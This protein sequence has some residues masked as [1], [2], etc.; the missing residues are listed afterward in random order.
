MNTTSNSRR[1]L[2]AAALAVLGA[3]IQGPWDFYPTDPPIFNGLTVTGY[4]LAGRPIEHV[5]FERLLPL[6]EENTQAFAFYDSA[7]VIITGN[8]GGTERPMTLTAVADTPNCFK[9]DP[10]ALVERGKNYELAAGIKWDSAGTKVTTVV[11]GTAR[12]PTSFSLHDSASAP[13]IARTGGV[14]E[15]IFDARFLASLPIKVREVMNKEYGDTLGKLQKDTV[16]LRKYLAVHGAAIQKRL[17]GLLADDNTIYHKGDTLFYLNGALNTLSHYYS[18]DRS[19]DVGSVLITQRF[20]P[21]GARPETSFDSPVGLKP[22]SFEYYFPGNH[23][24]LL[25]YPDGRSRKGWNLLDSIGVVNVFFHTLKNTLFF[26]GMEKAYYSYLSTVTQVQGGGGGEADPRVIPK[27]NVT[28]AHGVFVG[29]IP[30]SFDIVIRTDPLT[31]IYPL[32]LVHGMSCNKD[33]WFSGPDCRNYY[34]TWCSDT[35]WA[36]PECGVDAVMASLEADLDTNTELKTRVTAKADSFSRDETVLGMGVNEVCADRNFPSAGGA[37]DAS[38][39]ACLETQGAN[40]CKQALWDYCKDHSWRPEDHCGP[41][42]ASYCHDKPR[43][44]ETLCKHADEWCLAN[45][46]SVLCK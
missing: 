23:R 36:A 33:G 29:G 17:L 24:R 11:R 18:C 40:A 42:L 25:I 45:P 43:L 13:G 22:D 34:R 28:G 2:A 39:I 21:A 15:N 26:Y 4:A 35:A 30:D 41:A 20:D 14:P 1:F 44:S 37:C 10:A 27:F 6:D 12:V 46:G 31:K 16:A 7:E 9:G 3:C 32:P 8:F 19:P 5:C 38:R